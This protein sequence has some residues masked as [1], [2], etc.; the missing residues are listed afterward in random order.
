MHKKLNEKINSTFRAL[1]YKNYRLFF[2]GQCI[3]LIGTWIQQVAMS[4]LIYSLT[5]SPLIMGIIAFVSCIPSLLVSPFAGVVI[6]RI[7]KFY[8]M[9]M[10]QTIFMI[11]AF[12]IAT[13]ALTGVVQVWH[14]VVLSVLMGIANAFDIPLRQSFVV[15]LVD[16]PRDLSNAISLNSSSFNLAR[17]IGPA[18]A[19]VLIATVGE[20]LCF[21]LNAVSY[22]AVIFALFMMKMNHEPN[23]KNG[24]L[25]IISEFKEGFKYICASIPIRSIIL[26]LAIASMIGMSYPVIMPIFAKEILHGG[27]DTLG[28][29]MSASGVGALL[30]ALYLAGRKSVSGLEN[31]I[32]IA[33]LLFG[34]G[35]IGLSLT[36][37]ILISLGLMFFTGMGMVII[38]AASNTLIQHFVDDDKRGRVMSFYTMAFMGTVPIGCLF[39][40][41]I[42]DRIGVPHTFLLI[43]LTMLISAFIFSAKL[44]YFRNEEVEL[45]KLENEAQA[46]Q[47]VS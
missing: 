43:G 26:Y 10:T 29:L 42:A 33:S 38:I 25:N 24:K 12:I 15:Q 17:L 21:L 27:A 3:S 30:G 41:A 8:A 16:D 11:G 32:C 7:N 2:S 40:G 36:S 23:Y 22:V 20:G 5:K 34:F 39:G 19:G 14:V 4:W 18:V 37:N 9:I 45:V 35:F 47:E 13:L 28:F 6:D 31:W 1:Q 44:K 46:V